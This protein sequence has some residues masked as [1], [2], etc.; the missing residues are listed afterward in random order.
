[1]E[2]TSSSAVFVSAH[3]MKYTFRLV[4]YMEASGETPP[5]P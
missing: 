1:M 2:Y 4:Q 3:T 5:P